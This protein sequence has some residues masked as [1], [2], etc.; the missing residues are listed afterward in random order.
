MNRLQAT[1]HDSFV[2]AERHLRVIPRNIELLIHLRHPGERAGAPGPQ[3]LVPLPGIR[4]HLL[5]RRIRV[6]NLLALRAEAEVALVTHDFQTLF[7]GPPCL[8]GL[9]E[10]TATFLRA[11]EEAALSLETL[12]VDTRH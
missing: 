10:P 11:L 6:R 1:L 12:Q 5:T 3:P 8:L 2:E 4:E 9:A 7:S